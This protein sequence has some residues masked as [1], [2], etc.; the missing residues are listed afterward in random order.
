MKRYFIV[1]LICGAVG[2]TSCDSFLDEVPQSFPSPEG[3]FTNADQLGYY[4]MNYYNFGEV[5][6]YNNDGGT[7]NQN[8]SYSSKF[9]SSQDQVFVGLNQGGS[10]DF[11]TIRACN[12]FFE[13]VNERLKKG[14]ISGEKEMINHCIGEMY[15]I[16]ANEYFGKL[17]SLGDF[18]IITTVL[19]NDLQI[20]TDSTRR[21]PRNEVARFILSDLEKAAELMMNQSPDGKNLRLSSYCAKLLASR[22]A[23]YEATW[24]QNFKG[25]PFVPGGSGWPGEEIYKEYQYP[26]GSL[27]AE[28]DYFLGIAMKNAKDVADH[29]PLTTNTMA[30]MIGMDVANDSIA[31]M[32]FAEACYANDYVNMYGSIDKSSYPEV[33]MWKAYS[34]S[35]G[36]T[37]AAFRRIEESAQS[38][39]TRS[40]VD[41]YLMKNGLPIYASNSG[42]KGDKTHSDVRYNRD[43][44]IWLFLK[45]EGQINDLEQATTGAAGEYTVGVEPIMQLFA[46]NTNLRNP[47]GYSSRKGASFDAAQKTDKGSAGSIVFRATEA[48]L[49]YMEACYL[50]NGTLDDSAISYWKALRK[51]AGVSTDLDLTDQNTDIA[52]EA[53]TDWAAYTGGKLLTDPRLFNIRRERRCELM[54]EGLR[55][56]DLMRWRALDQLK[57]K[58]YF[59]EGFNFWD[60]NYMLYDP[61]DIVADK[62]SGATMSPQSESKY[63]RFMNRTD[64]S[65]I[66]KDGMRWMMAYYLDP[67]PQKVFT[68]A[69]SDGQ[70][71]DCP[72]YQNPYWK[73]TGNTPA[74]D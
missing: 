17:R 25:T 72:I 68:I 26:A 65:N 19:P 36:V 52:K 38:C 47:T 63:Y 13:Q 10:W 24:L 34:G 39:Y 53:E 30:S 61:N 42:Y 2:F 46:G 59:M 51:R 7:D 28:V 31:H 4:T 62:S 22:V 9:A 54:G 6:Y 45:E 11:G 27:E 67:I 37:N 3:Y 35:L 73:K 29:F 50:K 43:C 66:Y 33:L 58:P 74:L 18:P 23:L 8:G 56:M 15:M 48:Y 20:L 64:V 49:N 44:R 14:A 55:W 21:V 12:Y 60:Y 57:Y 40:G 70:G 71:T 41:C 32:A 5:N 69:S 1:M 16:R